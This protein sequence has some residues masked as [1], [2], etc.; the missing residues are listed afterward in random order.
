MS[1]L[2]FLFLTVSDAFL[3]SP[4][5]TRNTQTLLQSSSTDT[6]S[7]ISASTIY[8]DVQVGETP[9]GR[10][11][12][13]LTNPSP[14]PVH[15]ENIIQL[16]KGSRRGIDPKAHYVGCSFDYSPAT[17]QDGGGRYRWGHSL[18]G[19]GRNAVGRPDEPISDAGSMAESTHTCFGG[20]Y[21]GTKY[22]DEDPGVMLTVPVRGPG[23]G[24]SKLSIVRV[25]ESPPEWG[26][27]LLLNAGVIGKMLPECLPVLQ[28]MATQRIGPPTIVA[29]G[30]LEEED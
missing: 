8:F 25:G 17:L 18:V 1:L 9:L 10:L 30:T 12:F 3:S 20:Q 19:R 29:A 2:L 5:T 24:S 27:R 21:Y 28:A 6:I 7:S 23:Y 11:I 4:S 13:S 22:E 16:C 26:E 15:T 14:L